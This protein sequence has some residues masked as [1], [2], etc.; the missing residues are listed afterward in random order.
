[1]FGNPVSRGFPLVIPKTRQHPMS[2]PSR[3]RCS[4]LAIAVASAALPA[5][6]IGQADMAPTNDLPN[7]YRTIEGWAK[8]PDGRTWG[9]TSAVG[10]DPDGVSVWVGERCGANSCLNSDLDVILKFDANGN[11]VQSFG[12]GVAI[13][14]HG[15]H[16]DREGNV[17]LTDC[18]DNRP[19]GQNTAEPTELI[20]HQVFKFGPTGELLMTLGVKGGSREAGEY[21]WQPNAVVVAPNGDVFVSE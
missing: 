6:V 2:Q 8:M 10:I 21:F 1:M 16:V 4:L 19:R 14:P 7:P 12:S 20:G 9:S 11:L 5:T 15:F 18:Q 17:W 13:F 3:V